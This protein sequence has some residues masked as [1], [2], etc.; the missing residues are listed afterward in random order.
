MGFLLLFLLFALLVRIPP[1]QDHFKPSGYKEASGHSFFETV[2]DSERNGKYLTYS[3]NCGE[4]VDFTTHLVKKEAHQRI[5][6]KL[7]QTMKHDYNAK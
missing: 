1:N 6:E 4:S 5:T 7:K 2:F 3:C